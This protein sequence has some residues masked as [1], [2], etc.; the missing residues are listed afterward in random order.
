MTVF[1]LLLVLATPVVALLG[2]VLGFAIALP[3]VGLFLLLKALLRK[4][5]HRIVSALHHSH[6]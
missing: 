4:V 3:V 1:I 5:F 2:Q 6:A